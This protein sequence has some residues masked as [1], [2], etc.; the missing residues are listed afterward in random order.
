MIRDPGPPYRPLAIANEFIVRASPEGVEHMKLQKLVYYAYGWWLAYE[1]TSFI[2]EP[3]QIWQHGPVF[4]TLYHALK[5]HGR[6]P[7]KTTESDSP[8]AGPPR[9]D[10]E[11]QQAL[12]MIDW[13]WDRY[14]SYSSFDLSDMTHAPGSAW[15]I[16][17]ERNN[18]RVRGET[19]IPDEI[20]R[21]VF[22]NEADNLGLDI[23]A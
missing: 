21:E 15:H 11:D 1:K 22:L 13:V 12:E 7:I 10:P 4:K 23:G 20:I 14:K 3:P 19:T 18:W 8:F 6:K 5:H 17:A 16:V 2:S 9:V